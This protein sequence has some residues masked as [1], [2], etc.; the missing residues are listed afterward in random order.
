MN[1]FKSIILA[2]LFALGICSAHA[3]YS[4]Q[5]IV[6]L[7][8]TLA[9]STTTN[10]MQFI[11]C[12]GSQ[13]VSLQITGKGASVQVPILLG[14]TL[15]NNTNHLDYST[16]LPGPFN[17]TNNTYTT[18]IH[19]GGRGYMYV[20]AEQNTNSATTLTNDSCFYAFKRNRP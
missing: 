20:V 3:Q 6:N 16:W 12:T 15:D 5:I 4:G 17:T 13:E 19:V 1:K 18:N 10:V 14:Y 11:D 7:P 9:A 2:G 8:A